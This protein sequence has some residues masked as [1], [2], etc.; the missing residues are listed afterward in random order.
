MA[1]PPP[2]VHRPLTM[3]RE[4]ARI[5]SGSHNTSPQHQTR[6]ASNQ[7]QDYS[8]VENEMR[9]REESLDNTHYGRV[10]VP[11]AAG[12]LQRTRRQDRLGRRVPACRTMAS[13]GTFLHEKNSEAVHLNWLTATP[14]SSTVLLLEGLVAHSKR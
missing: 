7:T 11:N 8:G 6:Q 10:C 1:P 3:L 5:N 9:H 4:Q 14:P 12:Y 2:A 13:A